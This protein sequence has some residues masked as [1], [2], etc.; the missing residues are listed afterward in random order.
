[1]GAR[2]T[3]W[4]RRRPRLVAPLGLLLRVG[5]PPASRQE[6]RG[7]KLLLGAQGPGPGPGFPRRQFLWAEHGSSAVLRQGTKEQ[8]GLTVEIGEAW[9]RQLKRSLPDRLDAPG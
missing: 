3:V 5:V 1:M 8:V 6:W 7:A 4:G 2:P 9:W